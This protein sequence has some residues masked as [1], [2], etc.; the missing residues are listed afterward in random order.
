MV[1]SGGREHRQPQPTEPATWQAQIVIVHDPRSRERRLAARRR[2]SPSIPAHMADPV[3][4]KLDTMDTRL[5]E[6]CTWRGR[7]EC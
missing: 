2:Q 1:L 5:F 6:W 7:G 4:L 3:K